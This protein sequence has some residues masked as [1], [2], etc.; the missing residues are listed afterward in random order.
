MTRKHFV[1]LAYVLATLKPV[2]K[3]V[4]VNHYE[5]DTAEQAI[6]EKMVL[7]LANFCNEENPRFDYQRFFDACDL[8]R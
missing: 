8:E 2:A 7:E 1:K 4:A 5:V 6:W 3:E